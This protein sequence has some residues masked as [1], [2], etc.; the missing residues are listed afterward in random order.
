MV[1]WGCGVFD[2]GG[3]AVEEVMRE[4]SFGHFLREGWCD[5]RMIMIRVVVMMI[6][7]QLPQNLTGRTL[8]LYITSNLAR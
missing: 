5:V 6:M 2:G 1:G 8:M 3:D 4:V 7:N